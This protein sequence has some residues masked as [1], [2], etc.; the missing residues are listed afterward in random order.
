VDAFVEMFKMEIVE[1]KGTS[2]RRLR[3]T[4]I[5]TTS[6]DV[7]CLNATQS[8]PNVHFHG[9]TTLLPT[10]ILAVCAYRCSYLRFHTHFDRGLQVSATVLLASESPRGSHHDDSMHVSKTRR[11]KSC[12]RTLSHDVPDTPVESVVMCHV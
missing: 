7:G 8:T 6:N 3:Y 9:I 2:C 4:S 10:Q 1:K 5:R 11:P 12:T